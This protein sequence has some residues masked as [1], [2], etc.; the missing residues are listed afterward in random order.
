MGKKRT[1]YKDFEKFLTT[2]LFADLGIFALYLLFAG[3]SVIV[4]KIILALLAIAAAGF[5]LWMLYRSKEL[6]RNRSLWLTCAF[7]SITLLT[8]VSLICNFP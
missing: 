5:S 7:S 3:L 1:S 8:A 6:L 2:I 4:L